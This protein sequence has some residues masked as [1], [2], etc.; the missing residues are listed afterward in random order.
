MLASGSR[1]IVQLRRFSMALVPPSH[2][3]GMKK[4]DR[5]AF[6]Q[7][8]EIPYLRLPAKR[9]QEVR[10]AL[11]TYLLKVRLF[12]PVQICG[13]QRMVYLD[14][15]R[16]STPEDIPEDELRIGLS[17]TLVKLTYENWQ[18]GEVLRAVLPEDLEA[19]TS[20]SQVGHVLHLNLREAQLPYKE[21]IG[22]VYLDKVSH[23]RTVVNKTANIDA[24]FR[25]FS[26]EVLAGDLDTVV[27]AKENGCVY[28]LDFSR[29]YWNPRLGTERC[30]VTST[31]EP[32]DVLYDAFAGVG[33]FAIPAARKGAVVLANDLNPDSYHWLQQNTKINKL[34]GETKLFCKDARAFLKEDVAK[35]LVE[36]RRSGEKGCEHVVMN[37][38]ERALEFLDVFQDWLG[39]EE[40]R[41]VCTPLEVAPIV[42]LYCFVRPGRDG[43]PGEVAL[44]K[45]EERLGYELKLPGQVLEV[46]FVRNVAPGKEMMR[47]SFRVCPPGLSEVSNANG[48][49]ELEVKRV[50]GQ[51]ARESNG[52]EARDTADE[53]IPI[54]SED[55]TKNGTNSSVHR[56]TGD[57][58]GELIHQSAHEMKSD[59]TNVSI[60]QSDGEVNKDKD[61]RSVNKKIS[62]GKEPV[63]SSSIG[64]D[65]GELIHR[66]AGKTNGGD[67]FES[68]DQ[69]TSDR[70]EEPTKKRARK[71][72]TGCDKINPVIVKFS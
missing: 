72:S 4:L 67:I 25:N 34:K 2:V 43:D 56:P 14:P 49:I 68:T 10:S 36:R 31:L 41:M 52:N 33:P 42:H 71:E 3:R 12:K 46:R 62:D 24:E 13:E 29:V 16:V 58:N 51:E 28:R 37:L 39:P 5:E 23:C 59:V 50:G 38:P 1:F 54:S 18:P 45:V 66:T 61:L 6:T 70:F 32:G 27:E 9:F 17:R 53:P 60:L 69:S 7:E 55:I 40:V 11:K 64:N 26:M 20:Y 22:Q 44:K 48:G 35:H 47:V 15:R 8:V 65:D 63:Q 57:V 30:L 21:L 19:P